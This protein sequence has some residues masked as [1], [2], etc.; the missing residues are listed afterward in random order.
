MENKKQAETAGF[1][2]EEETG[3]ESVGADKERQLRRGDGRES[4]RQPSR[5]VGPWEGHT[6]SLSLSFLTHTRGQQ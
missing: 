3:S 6:T 1:S 4:R 2:G 5:A